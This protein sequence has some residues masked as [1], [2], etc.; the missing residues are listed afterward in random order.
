MGAPFGNQNGAKAKRW[1]AA[2][3]RA[4]I[5]RHGESGVDFAKALDKLADEFVEAVVTGNKDYLPGYRE[6]GDRIEGKPMQPTEI[7]G[8]EGAPVVS[9]IVIR[10]VDPK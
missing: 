6:L 2:I 5:R 4:I 1:S 8:P 3:E 9:E 7:S 10:S